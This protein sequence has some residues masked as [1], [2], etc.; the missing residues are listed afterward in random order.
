MIYLIG[1][2]G[3]A[4]VVLDALFAGGV[5]S[6]EII[7]R[8]G[9][10]ERAGA[11]LLGVPIETPEIVPGLSGAKVHVAVGSAEARRRLYQEASAAGA[12]ALTV[13]HPQ[14]R[15]S[16]F[17]EVAGG[18][19]VAAGAIVGPSARI[20]HGSIVN[21]GA[22]VDHDCSVGAYCHIAPNATLGGGAKVEDGALVG[23]GATV[24]PGVTVGAGSVVGAGA[25]VLRDIGAGEQ[26]AGVPALKRSDLK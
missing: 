12:E 1:S 15:L 3:H 6:G 8:D 25:V 20:G 7:L 19:F 4:K 11:R 2:K 9:D 14:A 22:V 26:W 17:A 18:V 5:R 24:L 13:I 23:A 10:E 16:A 21:H